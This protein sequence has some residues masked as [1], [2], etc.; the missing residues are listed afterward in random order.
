MGSI[1]QKICSSL[2]LSFKSKSPILTE[3]VNIIDK[4]KNLKE[5]NTSSVAF[6]NRTATTITSKKC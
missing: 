2:R 3:E 6:Q 1:E 5:F 4:F